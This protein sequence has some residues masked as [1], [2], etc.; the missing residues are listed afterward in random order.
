MRLSSLPLYYRAS[1]KFFIIPSGKLV[2][3]QE[4]S[5]ATRIKLNFHSSFKILGSHRK[6]FLNLIEGADNSNANKPRISQT[7]DNKSLHSLPNQAML[8][9]ST[10]RNII[11][12]FLK[13]SFVTFFYLLNHYLQV[14]LIILLLLCNKY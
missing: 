2:L 8:S 14:F 9:F 3:Q 1:T 13:T 4:N 11:I 5:S 7:P 6:L 10:Y 12:F